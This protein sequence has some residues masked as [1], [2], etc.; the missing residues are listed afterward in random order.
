MNRKLSGGAALV[1]AGVFVAG[2]FVYN[3]A[4]M[5][6]YQDSMQQPPAPQATKTP[7]VAVVTVSPA[8]YRAEVT[9]SG[10]VTAQYE[11]TLNSR[12]SGQVQS[13]A[14]AFD[15]GQWVKA[16]TALAQLDDSQLKADVESARNALATAQVSY[17]EEQQ[18]YDQ[19][20][21]EW[22]ISGISD[23]PLSLLV[24]REPQLKA[25][26]AEVDSARLTLEAAQRDLDSATIVA[27][28]DAVVVS[29]SIA[30][31]SYVQAGGELGSLLGA[32]RVDISVPLS[33]SQ[34]AALPAEAEL[35]GDDYPVS[36]IASDS[37]GSTDGLKDTAQWTGY[38]RH[39]GK[40]LDTSTRQR[41]LIVSV[42][43]P[44]TQATPLFPGTFVNVGLK[45]AEMSDLWQLP[46]SALS[47]RG[48]IWTVSDDNLLAAWPAQVKFSDN[49]H[50]YVTPVGDQT[51]GARV[52]VQP[53][54]SYSAGMS[55]NPQQENSD[56]E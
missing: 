31:G 11:L 10:S 7:T 44:L 39:T 38:V 24:L 18:S 20:R 26:Q 19:A 33:A 4:R 34:W 40:H 29:R 22:A 49:Q 23:E 13:V 56:G 37:A 9:G 25:A 17:L 41:S 43:Q 2:V 28:F 45:G 47:Q 6:S 16:G 15:A 54:S 46:A 35:L 12:V 51:D 53:L 52:L 1:I 27:P 30:P 48:E 55:V 50:I 3:S 36:L 32:E 8:T 42:D 14:T 21:E 5:S